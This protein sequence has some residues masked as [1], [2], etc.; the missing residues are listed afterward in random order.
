M[1]KLAQSL[2]NPK[3]WFVW[4]VALLLLRAAPGWAAIVTVTSAADSGPGSLR[5]AIAGANPGDYIDF[6]VA[7]AG[8]TIHLTSGELSIGKNLTIDASGFGEPLVIN[9]GGTSRVLEITAGSVVIAGLVLTNGVCPPGHSGGG[10]QVDYGTALTVNSC[11]ISGCV[12]TNGSA[13]GGIYVTSGS[14]LTLLFSTISGCVATNGSAGGGIYNTGSALIEYCTLINNTSEFG[15][16]IYNFS[17]AVVTL[18]DCTLA[19]NS[20][21]IG[22]FGSGGGIY[23][24]GSQT[25]A[26]NIMLN[27][28]TLDGNFAS[29]GGGIYNPGSNP[30][31]LVLTNTIVAGNTA[32]VGGADILGLHSGA[33]NFI[34]GDPKLAPLGNYGG[35]TLTMQPLSGSPVIDAGNDA[36]TNSLTYDQRI[37]LRLSGA[38]V[39]IGAVEVQFNGSANV[40][41][42]V[43]NV[44][45]SGNQL[46]FSFT[47]APYVDFTALTST[48]LALPP[49]NWTP[50]GNVT[51]ISPGHYQFTDPSATNRAQFYRVVSP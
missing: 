50:L 24:Y 37:S 7:L 34:G 18:N 11:T 6:A 2:S 3:T 19:G 38:H 8:Q 47:N 25:N 29:N 22:E 9:A 44:T 33:N 17:F 15:A 12:A 46:Q 13:G 48:N 5:T 21:V 10:I 14:S 16:G 41:F 51:E 31:Q 20:T 1:K 36:V 28:C 43:K 26:P 40:P 32:P 30:I 27:N 42:L 23:N 4:L 49:A 45:R 35:P 39:D